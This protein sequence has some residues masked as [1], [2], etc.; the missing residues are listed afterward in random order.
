MLATKEVIIKD[1]RVRHV[2]R[3]LQAN[4]IGNKTMKHKT[5]QVSFVLLA[6]A[7]FL[8]G[9][10]T[11]LKRVPS[12]QEVATKSISQI[13]QDY[14]QIGKLDRSP[15]GLIPIWDMPPASS[16]VETWGNPDDKKFALGWTLLGGLIFHP[17][18]YYL[19][20]FEGKNVKA[21]VDHPIAYG[22]RAHIWTL[23]WSPKPAESPQVDD[24]APE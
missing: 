1:E 15:M 17:S 4:M 19:W 10:A 12:R 5:I 13:K 22:Y 9:C 6:A 21:V 18:S 7:T 11:P 3:S 8:L 16:L 2:G 23:R 14:P 20:E 24:G